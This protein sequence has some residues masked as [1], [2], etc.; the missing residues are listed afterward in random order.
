VV[1]ARFDSLAHRERAGCVGR[2]NMSAQ[3]QVRDGET[4]RKIAEQ[5]MGDAIEITLLIR[6]LEG[7]NTGEINKELSEAGAANAAMV[8]RNALIVRLVILIAR[9]YA[10]PK[11]GDLHLR[12]GAD[13]LKNN[14]TRQVFQG[15]NG[16]AKIAAFEA[17]FAK[18]RGDHRLPSIKH[19]R[20]KY[21]AHL[22]EPKNIPE[23]TYRDLF[24]FG[25]ATAEV[26]ELLARATGV[27]VT[28]IKTDPD[29]LASPDAFWAPWKPR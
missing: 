3:P 29:L 17:Q 24:A 8:V 12:V 21:T 13:L 28:P 10:C 14:V 1:L 2:T 18:C 20:D 6:L 25:A 11:H 22:G 4:V 19:F 27:A 9:A 23:A 5:A 15:G 16:L 26:M 7:Q